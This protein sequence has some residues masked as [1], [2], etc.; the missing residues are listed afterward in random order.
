MGFNI[1]TCLI[2]SEEELQKM[3][4]PVSFRNPP[5]DALLTGDKLLCDGAF[6]VSSLIAMMN[7]KPTDK[8]V[9]M[10][11]K[12]ITDDDDH[13]EEDDDKDENEDE[14]SDVHQISKF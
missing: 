6:R 2:H 1:N 8:V 11:T 9:P 7:G 10:P 14:E 3:G 5:G 13:K 4:V 12:L